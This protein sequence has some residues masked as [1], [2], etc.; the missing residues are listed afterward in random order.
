LALAF[1]LGSRTDLKTRGELPMDPSHAHA[2]P[3]RSFC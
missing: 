3:S 2:M 1:K